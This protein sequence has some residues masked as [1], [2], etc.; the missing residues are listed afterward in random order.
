[1]KQLL[2]ICTLTMLAFT[3]CD[4]EDTETAGTQLVA[5]L[6]GAWKE[7]A[8]GYSIGGPMIHKPIPAEDAQMIGFSNGMFVSNDAMNEFNRYSSDSLTVT[9]RNSF[10]GKSFKYGYIIINDT[11]TLTP[12]TV[13]CV[14]GCYSKFART[15]QGK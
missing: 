4:K 7:V 11:L 5:S 14:E 13:M 6:E 15:E 3:A 1:M 9:L 2:A 12:L 8:I 10:T